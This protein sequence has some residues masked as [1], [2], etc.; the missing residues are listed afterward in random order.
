MDNTAS[1]PVKRLRERCGKMSQLLS[2]LIDRVKQ[3]KARDKKNLLEIE[4]L[5]TGLESAK[6]IAKPFISTEWVDV[7]TREKKNVV[8]YGV[9]ESSASNLTDKKAHDETK[10]REIFKAINKSDV[11][12]AYSRRLRSKDPTNPGP[13]LAY[14]SDAAIRNPVFLAAK[15]IE[16]LWQ[17]QICLH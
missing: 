13:L 6:K 8:I 17:I 15:K 7:V 2:L 9:P 11:S 12:V 5:K 16:R 4:R 14:L 1:K 10:I 3:L